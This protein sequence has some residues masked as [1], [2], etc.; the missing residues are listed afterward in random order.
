MIGFFHQ[1][2][3][4]TKHWSAVHRVWI[5]SIASLFFFG[6]VIWSAVALDVRWNDLNY[7]AIFAVVL[8]LPVSMIFNAYELVLCANATGGKLGLQK[9]LGFSSTATI[10]NVLPVPASSLI[11][12]G[13]L[14]S[15][16][17]SVV[18]SGKMILIAGLL[19]LAMASS[20]SALAILP[21]AFGIASFL[22]GLAVCVGLAI[23]VGIKSNAGIA[24]QFL[25]VRAAMVAL[26]MIRLFLCFVTI[27]VG[28]TLIDTAVF[29]VAGIIG[30][31]AAIVPAGIGVTESLGALLAPVSGTV[32]AAAFLALALNRLTGLAGAGLV[33]LFLVSGNPNQTLARNA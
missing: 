15:A 13:A 23:W 21:G 31:A 19:W 11:R 22:A 32:A 3:V 5:I 33:S 17:A 8:I 18:E 1:L 2:W 7:V 14:V 25:A 4:S 9:A 29:S 6:G 26:L 16:G 28:I 27:N 20:L 10:A 24:I 30:N 12:G